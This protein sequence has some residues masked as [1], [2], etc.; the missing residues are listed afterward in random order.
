M[1]QPNRCEICGEPQAEPIDMCRACLRSYWTIAE[2][3]EPMAGLLWAAKR[4]RWYAERKS[5][6]LARARRPTRARGS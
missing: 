1:P 3:R 2:S 5:A 4:A 6:R